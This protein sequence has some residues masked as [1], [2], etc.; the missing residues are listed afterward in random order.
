MEWYHWLFIC[1]V[2]LVVNHWNKATKRRAYL[3]NKY[4]DHALVEKLMQKTFWQGQTEDQ[5]FDSLG[6]PCDIDQKV[7]KTKTKEV[8]KYNKTGK[9]R[10]SLRVIVENGIVIGWDKK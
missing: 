3:M 4:R 5:L 8:W 6:K 1:F 10:Y 2:A 7:L 9:S